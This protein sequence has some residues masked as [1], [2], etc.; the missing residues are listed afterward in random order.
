LVKNTFSNYSKPFIIAEAGINHN[1]SV[2]TACKLVDVA[3]SNGADAIK[4]QTYKTQKRVG[5]INKKVTEILKKC[6][7]SFRDFIKINNYCRSKKITFFSTPFDEES[8]DFL[9]SINVPFYKIASVDISNYQLIKKIL[10]TKKPTIASTGMASFKEIMKID[11]MFRNSG[12]EL[13]IL[14]CVASYPNSEMSSYLSNIPFLLKKF[15]RTIGISDH[16]NEIKVPIY[17]TVLGAK[18]IEKHIKISNTHHCVDSPVSI[19]GQQLK[20]LRNEVDRIS[21]ILNKPSFGIRPEEKSAK[22]FKRK[23][24]YK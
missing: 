23:K 8:V 18:I 7:L 3:K 22:P 17:G 10:K 15:K 20:L 9:E 1:G 12:N 13:A 2:K 5:N 6:E 11:K 16:T 14:H 4:F 24:I 19:T 21:T